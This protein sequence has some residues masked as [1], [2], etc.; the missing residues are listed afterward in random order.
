MKRTFSSVEE[1]D[2]EFHMEFNE[3]LKILNVQDI[4]LNEN[5]TIGS[6]RELTSNEVEE[7]KS[8][9]KISEI[10]KPVTVADSLRSKFE[11]ELAK[12]KHLD[13]TA[14]CQAVMM[15]SLT[16][17]Q[18]LRSL[19]PPAPWNARV[20]SAAASQG[21]LDIIKWARAQSPPCP[22]DRRVCGYAS[23][24]GHSSLLR[25]A[26]DNGCTYC[27][28]ECDIAAKTGEYFNCMIEQMES[29][30]GFFDES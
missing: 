23:A 18:W 21:R 11:I 19:C 3:K 25:W 26:I 30:C 20:M 17:L 28:K 5:E 2:N 24:G 27:E 13:W 14:C 22:W 1:S 7:R 8:K 10:P 15:G 29:D 16:T 6:D 9:L 12:C 4:L